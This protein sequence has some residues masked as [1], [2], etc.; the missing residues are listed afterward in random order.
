[1]CG[2]AGYIGPKEASPLLIVALER[3][4]YRGYDSA[5]IAVCRDGDI[6]VRKSAGRIKQLSDLVD[7]QPAL[8]RCGIGHSR[9]ATH[10][11]PTSA[12]AHPHTSTD[13]QIAVVHNGII[14]NYE[15]IK[16]NLLS[17]GVVFQ[18]QTDT[19]VIPHL[20][21]QVYQG[22]PLASVLQIL[23]K[24]EGSYAFAALFSDHCQR[25]IAARKGS[26]LLLGRGKGEVLIASD[27]PALLPHAHE[28]AALEDGQV[29]DLTEGNI[30][31]Y[32]FHGKECEI[33]WKVIETTIDA[34]SKGNFDSF[35]AKEIA[36]QPTVLQ[37][38]IESRL[39]GGR[40][41]VPDLGVDLAKIG[42]L[43]IL[44]CGTSWHAALLGKR[45][46]EHYA[47]LHVEVDIS[48]E[49][50]YRNPVA[51]GDSAVFAIS[52]SGETADTLAGLRLAR[53]RF[54]HVIS[55]VNV[56][57]S[58]IARESDGVQPLM[59]GPEIGVASTKAYTAQVLSLYFFALQVAVAKGMLGGAALEKALDAARLIPTQVA[60]CLSMCED[61]IIEA[62]D[63]YRAATA[64]VFM[65]RGFEY[66]TALEGALKLKE[67]AYVHAMGYAAGEFKHGPIA[68]VSPQ[69]PV[70]CLCPQDSMYE[71]MLSNVEE[72][73]A[74]HG[75]IIA[76]TDATH[77]VLRE[78]ADHLFPMPRAAEDALQPILSILP[79]QRYAYH[80]AK[81]RGCDVDQP[82]N[83]AKSV[84]VE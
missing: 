71:K 4:K 7:A 33:V 12:N 57:E 40:L 48:S 78:S 13:G 42:H 20:L 43:V 70:V 47:R 15:V 81:R 79:L 45:F 28:Y 6:A 76:V 10:G 23:P 18:S 53:S 77:G 5:G 36:E 19:E 56:Q 26:P 8:G 84:T 24:L 39:S 27:L 74:R 35:M 34:V 58:T 25:I 30:R 37:R 38:I 65:G 59:A 83:L 67:I 52:Q 46:L 80:I 69:L 2:I 14:E 16:R 31:V 55:L 49:F 72:V 82:R 3:L 29:A 11:P 1:M 61:P 66:P 41:V 60:A 75:K 68:L 32:D 22:D 17:Q 21:A 50:R 9:W 51:G 64:T 44:A 62:A 63:L 54:L 73:R